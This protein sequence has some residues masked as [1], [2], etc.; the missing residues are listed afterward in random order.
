MRKVFILFFLA[1]SSLCFGDTR[2]DEQE[3][4][5]KEL[6]RI[7]DLLELLNTQLCHHAT[8]HQQTMLLLGELLEVTK[9]YDYDWYKEPN[10]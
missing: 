6:E 8:F 10:N 5:V 3:K 9:P 2:H 7:G 4:V 1:T